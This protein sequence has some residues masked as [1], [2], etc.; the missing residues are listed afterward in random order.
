[1]SSETMK[2]VSAICG[3]SAGNS[4]MW[5]LRARGL[6]APAG[7]GRSHAGCAR[8]GWLAPIAVHPSEQ[9]SA[10]MFGER[11]Q[12]PG[13][14]SHQLDNPGVGRALS[15]FALGPRSKPTT[16]S[17]RLRWTKQHNWQRCHATE[18]TNRTGAALAV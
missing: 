9:P 14:T 15:D 11:G 4:A 17:H 2:W 10:H 16:W 12:A 7:A 3:A 1:M 8:V 13:W 18:H 5:H 6:D